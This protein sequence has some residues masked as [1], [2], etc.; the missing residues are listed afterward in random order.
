MCLYNE[1]I[2]AGPELE[3][4]RVL[5][6]LAHQSYELALVI[7]AV[8]PVKIGSGDT[9]PLQVDK[10]VV[11]GDLGN[12]LVGVGADSP[13][14]ALCCSGYLTVYGVLYKEPVG[15]FTCIGHSVL[16][17][18]GISQ[19]YSLVILDKVY[20]VAFSAANWIPVECE[21]IL[22]IVVAVECSLAVS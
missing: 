7:C 4:D 13:V 21:V 11:Y 3:C 2:S 10:A 5:L 19:L 14:I 16:G 9:V 6:G 15:T 8:Y 18:C 1:V 22:L 17:L 12:R 20:R